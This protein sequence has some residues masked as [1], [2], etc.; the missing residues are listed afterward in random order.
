MSSNRYAIIRYQALDKCFRNKYCRFYMED[1]IEACNE[2][3]YDFL[4]PNHEV[5]RRQIF[6]DIR[7][8]ESEQGWNIPLERIPDGKRVYY[9]Y[10]KPF[11]INE[12]PL[13]DDEMNILTQAVST[14]NRFKG[15][16]QFE[17]IEGLLANLEDKFYL[18]GNGDYVIGFEQNLDYLAS[19]HL[20][21]LFNAIVNKQVVR[22]DYQT[23]KG[24][25][26]TWEI[27]PYFI[28]QYNNRWFLFGRN[29]KYMDE[30]VTI[31]LDRIATVE[32]SSLPYIENKDIDFDEYFDDIIGV[33]IP[34]EAKKERVVLRFSPERFPYV[35]S[36]PLHGSMRVV[37]RE[38]G[39][40]E[41][42]II[43]N[44]EFE[45]LLF[46][47]GETVEVIEPQWI[48]ETI[49]GKIEKLFK[50]YPTCADV[51]HTSSLPLQRHS[52][53]DENIDV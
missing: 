42:N 29:N 27:H 21:F 33:T 47:F 12:R 9:R 5:K 1:L 52:E 7:F 50:K 4:G 20:H 51:V 8:M 24:K 38:N 41:L 44:K 26:H 10:Y 6:D 32:S 25:S 35:E 16:P 2:A 45:A 48:R 11:S 37:D 30:I 13:S 17:W 49:K 22:V 19:K 15:L 39:V 23:F 18:R 53:M 43:P 3:L 34:K 40:V 46:S 36:K 31:P 28:K 14:L